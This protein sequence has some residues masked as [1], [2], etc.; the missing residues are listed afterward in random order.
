VEKTQTDASQRHTAKDERQQ[1]PAARQYIPTGHKG[2]NF[3]L[4]V[5]NSGTDYPASLFFPPLEIFKI[6]MEKT[7]RKHVTLK[8]I[9]SEQGARPN[10]LQSSL[11]TYN[12]L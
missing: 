5:V 6:G 2:K 12:F 4:K 9:I 3:P 11:P 1:S 10:N 8:L 7:L